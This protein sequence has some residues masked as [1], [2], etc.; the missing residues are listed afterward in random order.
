MSAVAKRVLYDPQV[1]KPIIWRGLLCRVSDAEIAEWCG[2][3][4]GKLLEW[5]DTYPELGQL[6]AK[7]KG[8]LSEVVEAMFDK[9]IGYL[10]EQGHRQGASVD[11]QKFLLAL[12]GLTPEKRQEKDQKRHRRGEDLDELGTS[13]LAETGRKLLR[14]IRDKQGKSNLEESSIFDS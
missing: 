6:R 11:A 5:L 7:A 8:R 3:S 2:V 13:E 10:D 14:S 9:A 12:V 4:E 1:H